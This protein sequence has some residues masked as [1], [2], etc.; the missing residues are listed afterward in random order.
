MEYAGRPDYSEEDFRLAVQMF[1]RAIDLDPGFALA[2]AELS[3]AHSALYF[4]GHDRTETSPSLAKAA[5][6]RALELQPTLPDAHLALG[7]YHYWCRQEFGH[8]LAEFAIAERDLHDDARILAVVAAILKRQGKV[9]QTVEHY[10]RA[11]E[12]SPQDASLPHE[13]GCACMT[14]RDYA[15]AERYYDRSIAL[16]PDQVFAYIC[17]VWNYWLWKDDM[18]GARR[19]LEA[20]PDRVT[21]GAKR[22]AAAL[23][24]EFQLELFARDYQRALDTLAPASAAFDEG[25]WWFIPKALVEAHTY[26]L[27]GD[28]QRARTGFESALTML[29]TEAEQRPSDDRVRASMGIAYAG[30]GRKEDA[31]R[32]GELAVELMPV[33]KNA[34][35]GPY[36]VEDL[37]FVYALVGESEKAL[38]RLEFLLSIPCWLS[39]PVLRLDPRWDPLRE[40]PRFQKLLEDESE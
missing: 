25:Q 5:V 9:E 15:Q 27:A 23:F 7:Y 34:V 26:R 8:A 38:D 39:V 4:H 19:T 29:R 36:R 20:I 12:L 11:F 24:T 13:I 21:A 33:A 18:A 10:K 16:A 31:I 14:M 22:P 40:H 35:I 37:A 32:E 28:A 6:G 30:L 17:K 2:H 1:E 3:K